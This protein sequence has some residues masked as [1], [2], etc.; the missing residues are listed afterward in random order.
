MVR[1]RERERERE[2]MSEGELVCVSVCARALLRTEVFFCIALNFRS[3]IF[4]GLRG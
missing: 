4:F 3:T 2:K 1:E